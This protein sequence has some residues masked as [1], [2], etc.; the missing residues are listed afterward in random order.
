[1]YPA[2]AD[3]VAVQIYTSGTTGLP[4]GVDDDSGNLLRFAL[5]PANN[6]ALHGNGGPIRM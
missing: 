1:M 5:R 2:D 4:K 6:R 3:T